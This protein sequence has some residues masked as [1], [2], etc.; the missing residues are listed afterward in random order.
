LMCLA[1][2]VVAII[3]GFLTNRLKYSEKILR[4]R[5][6]RT[7]VLYGILQ[8]ISM[9][10]EKSEFLDKVISRVGS[11]LDADCGVLLKATNGQLSFEESKS[12][13]A[14]LSEK[15]RAVAQWSFDKEKSAG[16]S[17]DTLAETAALFVPLRG[18]N[19]TVGVFVL[20]PKNK[21][22]KIDLDKENL[23]LSVLRQLGVSIE[24]HFLSKRVAENQRLKDSEELHE[25][26]LN[27]I[28]HEMRTPLT[29]ILGAVSTLEQAD[30]WSNK[31]LMQEVVGGLQD[32][33]E[34]LNQVIENLL[35]MS[36]INSGT[37]SLKFEWNEVNDLVGVV[38]KKLLRALSHHKVKT[39]YLERM[40]LVRIDFRMMEHALSNIILNALTYSPEN[41]EIDIVAESDAK[42][43]YIK[44]SDQG[45]GIP[46]DSL[47]KIF[48]KFYR[49]PGSAAGGT[50]LGLS[51][52][53]SIV[54]IHRGSV[55]AENLKPFG[56]RFV[57]TLPLEKQPELPQEKFNG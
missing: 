45:P 44:I 13:T 2:M 52:V 38:V 23:L 11:V 15:E 20:R 39:K 9:A 1:F 54:E 16:W 47:D 26:L 56:A 37:I 19:E 17:T 43:I 34:R 30:T 28:S 33:G 48:E 18:S 36:R 24:R 3:T 7:N 27:S 35:D 42:N 22:R 32:S 53:K 25:T 4:E 40:L 10:T 21:S 29:A 50:G 12:Y 6:E 5:E 55:H 8:D 51:I 41:S 46:E 49:L 57:I 14:T 31:K